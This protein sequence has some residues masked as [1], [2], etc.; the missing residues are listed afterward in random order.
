MK[1]LSVFVN[2]RLTTWLGYLILVLPFRYDNWETLGNLVPPEWRLH[3]YS[4]LGM[5]VVILRNRDKIAAILKGE[6]E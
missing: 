6:V 1:V 4:V 3:V 2:A 5:L